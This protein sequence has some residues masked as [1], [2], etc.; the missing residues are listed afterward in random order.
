[1][2][3]Q[4]PTFAQVAYP[5]QQFY[6]PAPS[7]SLFHPFSP[8]SSPFSSFSASSSPSPVFAG[9]QKRQL[10]EFGDEHMENSSNNDNDKLSPSPS[11]SSL[12]LTP[13]PPAMIP[14]TTFEQRANAN[15]Y[16][17]QK[18]VVSVRAGRFSE[19]STPPVTWLEDGAAAV[20]SRSNGGS[21]ADSNSNGNNNIHN[22]NYN[23]LTPHHGDEMRELVMSE[24]MNESRLLPHH[25]KTNNT[26]TD[27]QHHADTQG[28]YNNDDMDSSN[29]YDKDAVD[30]ALSRALFHSSGGSN[31]KVV[32][33]QQQHQQQQQR[34]HN[35]AFISVSSLKQ[36]LPPKTGDDT[37]DGARV[38]YDPSSPSYLSIIIPSASVPSLQNMLTAT[39]EQQEET[40][41]NSTATH[42]P[43]SATFIQISTQLLDV[44][45]LAVPL[46]S[47]SSS[48][49][50]STLPAAINGGVQMEVA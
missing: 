40:E 39:N 30:A 33:E 3:L 12:P 1:M 50:S 45:L 23:N 11:V 48:S 42:Q 27:D 20:G 10:L 49:A 2:M 19:S 46:A 6:S 32:I 41:E 15:N 29:D 24:F 31:S 17:K 8:S 4:K 25:A 35:T 21:F 47:S 18:K 34:P 5:N 44:S 36:I 43:Q 13:P 26:A 28:Y 7:N 16:N 22:N 38:E 14:K 37:I 9:V